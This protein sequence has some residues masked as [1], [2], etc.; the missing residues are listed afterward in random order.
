MVAG[1]VG[2]SL[3]D[4][5]NAIGERNMAGALGALATV[6]EAGHH[7]VEVLA[8][9]GY[10]VHDLWRAAEIGRRPG[11]WFRPEVLQQVRLHQPA[12]LRRGAIA[13]FDADRRLKSSGG[14]P[15]LILERLVRQ[16]TSGEEADRGAVGRFV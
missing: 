4:L 16:L 7:P 15:R 14:D 5:V 12:A 6:L 11:V 9:V 3:A 8:Y 10:R 1:G 2:A 13:L